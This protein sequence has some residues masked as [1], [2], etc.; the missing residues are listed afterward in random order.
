[1]REE[2]NADLGGTIGPPTPNARGSFASLPAGLAWRLLNVYLPLGFLVFWGLNLLAGFAFESVGVDARIYYRGS[3]AWL[4]G[5][6]PWAA[7]TSLHGTLF[8]YAG[9]PPTTIALAPFTVLPEDVFVWF[10]VLS[11]AAAAVILI[12]A[13]RLPLSWVAY[14]PLAYAVIAGNPQVM[15]V[16]LVVAGGLVGGALAPVLKVYAFAPLVGERRWRAIAL[17]AALFALSVVLAPG[18][19]LSFFAQ[20]GTMTESLRR[21]SGAGGLSAWGTPLLMAAT[22]VALVALARIDLA[23]AGW[24]VIPAL[25]PA[26]QY[27]APVMSLPVDPL[28]A[29]VMAIPIPGAVPVAT[30]GYAAIRVYRHVHGARARA[31]EAERPSSE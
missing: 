26:T 4:S 13:L 7:A 10:V 19:W 6:T 12:R 9:L 23:A 28:L 27:Y 18:L 8:T 3:A 15:L 20:A 14:P 2:G 16:A 30:V 1:M 22:A 25:W 31:P 29:S 11:S 5:S 24:L 17:G 21:E